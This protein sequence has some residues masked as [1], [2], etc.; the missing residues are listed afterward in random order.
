MPWWVW[1]FGGLAVVFAVVAFAC[2]GAL[3][4][5]RTWDKE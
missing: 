4:P 5:T 2:A 1:I 3:L